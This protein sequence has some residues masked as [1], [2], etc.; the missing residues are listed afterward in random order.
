M[1]IEPGVGEGHELGGHCV[2][3]VGDRAGT[4]PALG[5]EQLG[6]GLDHRPMARFDLHPRFVG[7]AFGGLGDDRRAVSTRCSIA[8]TS[9][10]G[11][12]STA[13]RR[14]TSASCASHASARSSPSGSCPA[15]S[16]SSSSSS[17]RSWARNGA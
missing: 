9:A 16:V 5:R 6:L 14:R 11:T 8:A 12:G 17:S 10:E 3:V 2:F 4:V 1:R 13:S 15:G 7:H